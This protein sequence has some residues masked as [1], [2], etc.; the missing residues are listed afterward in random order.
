MSSK[1]S[2][3]KK[4]RLKDACFFPSLH[5]VMRAGLKKSTES[6]TTRPIRN[7][8]GVNRVDTVTRYET[9][10]GSVKTQ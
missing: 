4:T 7:R 8:L 1:S 9:E 3:N 5:W 6:G 2:G 10:S